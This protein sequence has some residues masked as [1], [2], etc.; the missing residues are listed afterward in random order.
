[1][2]EPHFP[3]EEKLGTSRW[4]QFIKDGNTL[5]LTSVQARFIYT[6]KQEIK[7][8]RLCKESDNKEENSMTMIINDFKK[9]IVNIITLQMEL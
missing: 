5:C 3:L 8:D 9:I 6:M 7:G 2:K 4:A 1:M